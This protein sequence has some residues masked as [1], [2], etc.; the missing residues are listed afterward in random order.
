MQDSG[1]GKGLKY[2]RN[3]YTAEFEYYRVEVAAPRQYQKTI[4]H[5]RPK[6]WILQE[7]NF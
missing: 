4:L 6:I 7:K 3:R 1:M 2:V 5:L